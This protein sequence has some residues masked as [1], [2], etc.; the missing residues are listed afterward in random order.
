MD[1][2]LFNNLRDFLFPPGSKRRFFARILS[3]LL[4]DPKHTINKINVTNIKK[5]LYYIR[6]EDTGEFGNRIN[7]YLDKYSPLP[8]DYKLDLIENITSYEKLCF[9]KQEHPVVSIVIPVYNQWTY[10]YGCLLSILRNTSD[11]AYEIIIVDDAS[12]DETKNISDFVQNIKIIRNKENQGFLKNCNRG[13][14]EALGKYIVFLNNDTCVQKEWLTHLL[15]LMERDPFAGLAG[16]KLLYPDGRLQEAGGIVWKDASAWN[17]GRSDYPDKSEYNYVKEVDYISGASVMIRKILWKETGGFDERYI[18]AYSEDSDLA[19][20]VR[21]RGYKVLYQPKSVVVH[22]EGLTCGTDIKSGIK[23][24]QTLNAEKF[25]K[26]WREILEKEHFE[27]GLELFLA[28]ER[29]WNKKLILIIDHY[30]PHY[31]K[32]AGSKTIFQYIRLFLE[33]GFNVK[34]AGDN[35]LRPEPY[36][37]DLEQMGIEVLYGSYYRDNWKE[38]IKRNGKYINYVFFNRPHVT[39]K[40]IDFIKRYTGAK[41][42]YYGHDLHYLREKRRYEIEKKQKVFETPEYWR[43]IEFNIFRKANIVYYPSYVEIEEV[44]KYFPAVKAKVLPVYIFDKVEEN[45]LTSFENRK[46]LLFVAGFTHPPNEDAAFWFIKEIFPLILT[47]IPDIKVYLVGSNPSDKILELSSDNIII[48]GYVSDEVLRDYYKKCRIFVAPL[49]YGA[50]LK[51]KIVEALYNKI[52]VVTTSVGAEGFF[53]GEEFLLIA[54]NVEE[55]ARKVVNSY[56][57]MKCLEV[58]ARKGLNYV[59]D[60]F[61]KESVLRVIASDLDVRL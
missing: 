53:K 60:N 28:R 13:A 61:S 11:I 14:K 55:F 41:I 23:S 27:N 22:F 17:Y 54:H 33:L 35:F 30:V 12:E 50:G 47:K 8:S 25:L 16:S 29:S 34:F 31:D 24:Y 10:T 59:K 5:F 32:D 15:R 42:L 9:E 56:T 45:N 4:S 19:F 20:E 37:S 21:K 2:R 7:V 43:K 49:R 46:D 51:G 57:D 26:K 36:T 3:E 38:W 58:L 40:Y 48:T 44:K 52:P 18:P 39:I 1:K 6:K